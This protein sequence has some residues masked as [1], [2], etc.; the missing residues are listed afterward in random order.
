[1]RTAASTGRITA[2][3]RTIGEPLPWAHTSPGVLERYL[4]TEWQKALTA[5]LTE[6]C[7]RTHCTGCGICPTLGV[8]VIDYAGEEERQEKHGETGVTADPALQEST[9]QER[10]A[11]RYRGLITKGRSCATSPISTMQTSLSARASAQGFPW[12]TQRALTHT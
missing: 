1:M 11:V 12:H 7:R 10:M 8:D 3:A 9:P 4:K 2:A 6:D 5:S